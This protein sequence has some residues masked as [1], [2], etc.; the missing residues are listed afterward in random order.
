MSLSDLSNPSVFVLVSLALLSL[1]NVWPKCEG[2]ATA[3]LLIWSAQFLA[4]AEI[5]R[6]FIPN[7]W[8]LG[9][10]GNVVLVLLGLL[11]LRYVALAIKPFVDRLEKALDGLSAKD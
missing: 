8:T 10:L 6:G 3:L 5:E 11:A 2:G 1:G 7:N 4:Q 9:F